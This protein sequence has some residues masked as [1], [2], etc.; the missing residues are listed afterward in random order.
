MK[1]ICLNMIVKNEAHIIVKTLTNICSYINFTYWVISDTGST[2]QTKKLIRDFFKERNIPGELNDEPWQD[3]GYNRTVA[4]KQAFGKTDYV[5]V[6]DA[7]DEIVGDFKLPPLEAD[8]YRFRFGNKDGIRL[9]RGQLFNNRKRWLYRGVLHEYFE[10]LDIIESKEIVYGDYYFTLGYE[11]AR[12]KDPNKYKK[13]ALILEKAFHDSLKKKDPIFSRYAFYCANSCFLGNQKEKA[14]EYY[15][16]VLTMDNW[17]QE[18]YISCL[19]IYEIYDL[20][21]QPELGLHFL[22]Q[23][24]K[25]DKKRVECV[26]RLIKYYC[27][28]DAFDVA[29]MY[30]SLIKDY[31]ENT[32]F[33]KDITEDF[34]SVNYSEYSF[35][36][37]YYMIIAAG[38]TK[39]CDTGILMYKIICKKKFMASEWFMKNL[40]SNLQFFKV[41]QGFL[42]EWDEYIRGLRPLQPPLKGDERQNA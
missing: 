3:F 2:D 36:L 32:Y 14:L 42:N 21:K 20:Q 38:Q 16:K 35:F 26:F 1:T 22:V 5:F 25:Y 30:Y 41:D 8:L 15:K 19:R 40:V 27:E 29:Y 6:W 24:Y 34:L 33:E 28:K 31:Y 18:K 10:C 37:P 13:D 4:L 17:L 7:D 39:N 23:S 9:I 12:N 11:G